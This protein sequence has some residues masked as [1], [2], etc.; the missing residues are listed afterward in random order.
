MIIA[1]TMVSYYGIWCMETTFD[2]FVTNTPALFFICWLFTTVLYVLMRLKFVLWIEVL[3][4]FCLHNLVRK[5]EF[6]MITV[7]LIG[8]EFDNVQKSKYLGILKEK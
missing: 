1:R 6:N 8:E 3:C 5:T 7:A 4:N 2:V